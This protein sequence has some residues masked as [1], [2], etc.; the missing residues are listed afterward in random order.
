M[1][2]GKVVN[3]PTGCTLS[4]SLFLFSVPVI[5]PAIDNLISELLQFRWCNGEGEEVEEDVEEA[6]KERRCCG[7]VESCT[8]GRIP[9]TFLEFISEKWNWHIGI[10]LTV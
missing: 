6:E 5:I 2:R 8:R 3:F 4:L 10:V 1:F 9:Y 7:V